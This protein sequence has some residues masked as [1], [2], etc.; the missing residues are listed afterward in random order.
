MGK[1]EEPTG[2]L[3]GRWPE[4][5]GENQRASGSW[6]QKGE[7][8]VEKAWS[9]GSTE[10]G[11]WKKIRP[12]PWLTAVD[13]VP[14]DGGRSLSNPFPGTYLVWLS[15]GAGTFTHLERRA[16]VL[17]LRIWWK[18]WTISLEKCPSAQSPATFASDARGPINQSLRG[19]NL[20]IQILEL[21][22]NAFL[23][24]L[25]KASFD[26]KRRKY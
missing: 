5:P 24:V 17:T 11:E 8:G 14:R 18:P 12:W 13:L 1:E 25:F 10:P 22:F 15:L 16:G 2:T 6:E 7:R 9:P 19:R 3:M 20:I 4:M 26:S 21:G 23:P